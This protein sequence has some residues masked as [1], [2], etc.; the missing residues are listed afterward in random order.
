MTDYLF[1]PAA[2]ADDVYYRKE[3][4]MFSL[5]DNL[6]VGYFDVTHYKLGGGIRFP[7][8]TVPKYTA[9]SSVKLRV[10]AWSSRTNL[11]CTSKIRVQLVD[12]APIFT[13]Q[14][15]FDGRTF[16]SNAIT[17]DITSDWVKD[18]PYEVDITALVQEI[19]NRAGWVSGNAIVIRWEDWDDLSPHSMQSM[20]DIYD[21]DKADATKYPTLIFSY[22]TGAPPSGIENFL[23]LAWVETDPNSHIIVSSPKL[24]ASLLDRNEDCG[25][26][27]YYGT[28]K[29]G[30]FILEFTAKTIY[31]GS[32]D[33]QFAVIAMADTVRTGGSL[34][35]NGCLEV[36]FG[37]GLSPQMSL[38]LRNTDLNMKQNAFLAKNTVYYFRFKRE[39]GTVTLEAYSDPDRITLV[40]S[41]TLDTKVDKLYSYIGCMV[42]YNSGGN[43]PTYVDNGYIENLV[44]SISGIGTTIPV[45]ITSIPTPPHGEEPTAGVYAIFSPL[46]FNG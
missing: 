5:T 18:S 40:T 3:S 20:R 27:K 38:T 15:N 34:S 26:W 31:A 22:G 7:N 24:K 44:V 36:I 14:S 8:I 37:K 41:L 13:D 11:P 33:A 21:V 1:K 42:S 2:S 17:W 29:I 45:T 35:P 16:S 32:D 19:I 25:I 10:Y 12:N 23:S 9:L 43:H 28:Q 4:P 46:F 30:D 39:G 6:A